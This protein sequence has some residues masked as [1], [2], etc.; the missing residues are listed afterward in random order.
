M[1]KSACV[2]GPLVLFVTLCLLDVA[3]HDMPQNYGCFGSQPKVTES[4][5]SLSHCSSSC[6]MQSVYP[7]KIHIMH[8]V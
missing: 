3:L 5:L 4:T 8:L 7:N 6:I 1:Q 2:Y